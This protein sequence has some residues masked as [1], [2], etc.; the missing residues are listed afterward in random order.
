[1]A[2]IREIVNNQCQVT[3]D[4]KKVNSLTNRII[5]VFA[6]EK[7]TYGGAKC[8]LKLV[9]SELDDCLIAGN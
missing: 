9:E 2:S 5:N 6:E 3:V 8:I 7:L 1:M 4:S